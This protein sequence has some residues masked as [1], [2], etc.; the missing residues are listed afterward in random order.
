M[1]SGS[2]AEWTRW[3]RDAPVEALLTEPTEAPRGACRRSHRVRVGG[4][5]VVVPDRGWPGRPRREHLGPLLPIPGAILDGSNGDIACGHHD[6]PATD[7]ELMSALGLGAYRF[8]ISWPRVIPDGRGD[9]AP[10]GLDFYDR[11]VDQLL[12][13]GIEPYVTLYHWD[14]PQALE[15]AGGWPERA[16][17]YHFAEYADVV[18][19]ASATA[20]STGR[21]STS[22]TARATSATPPGSWRRAGRR[23]PTASP[24]P[25]ICCSATASPS[26]GCARVSPTPRSA[27]SST[28]ARAPG[29]RPIRPTSR[30][31]SVKDA[32]FN[33]WF[34]EP[35]AGL[36][37]P[38][39]AT[40]DVRWAGD[41][42]PR[43]RPRHH[44]RAD[45]RAR[46]QLLHPP[47]VDAADE[48][49]APLSPGD[50][51]G[52]GDLPGGT[53]RDAA[54]A[55]RPLPLPPLPRHRERGGDGRPSRRHRLRRR[56]GPH[57]LPPP[58]LASSTSSSPRG[59]RSAATSPG[60]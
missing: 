23:S 21:R 5:D 58:H 17:A 4:G 2:L 6:T 44:R 27:S 38:I 35:I 18:A 20:S 36:G 37:Y 33:R 14:L 11:L 22:R 54:L 49:V 19:A 47:L 57:R 39:D 45:R 43:R 50:G 32:L 13:A 41:R 16:T 24:P 15:D 25:T 42:D 26:S 12:A 30:P 8:S 1:T 3:S 51:D 56:P 46:R 10:A 29:E 52:L 31:P 9:V 55:A 48:H 34:V 28:S 40:G 53:R 59:S 7:V 60:A